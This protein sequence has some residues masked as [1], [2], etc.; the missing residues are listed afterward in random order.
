M[1]KSHIACAFA[2]VFILFLNSLSA[3][4]TT[5]AAPRVD[6]NR[7]SVVASPAVVVAD[8]RA[9]ATILVTVRGNNGKPLS[10]K[11]VTLSISPSLAVQYS[12]TSPWTNAYGQ[13]FFY[14]TSLD[15]GSITFTA[16]VDGVTIR[17][18][19]TVTY[20]APTPV[21]TATY[22]PTFVATPWPTGTIYYIPPSASLSTVS[23][24]P[25]AVPADGVTTATITVAV[26]DDSGL[27]LV[28]RYVHIYTD[29]SSSAVVIDPAYATTNPNG[30]V[31]AR[32]KSAVAGQFTIHVIVD[33]TPLN[34]APVLTFASVTT[35]LNQ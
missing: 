32:A 4:T 20:V 11:Y 25:D 16:S 8:G 23:V 22:T 26:V 9:Y 6:P 14:A 17:Q 30:V 18:T 1:K 10:G 13:A 3:P 7:S 31:T 21:P 33:N 27:P 35:T 19:A 29:P 12:G 5:Q 2:V 15:A 24:S 28:G 34:S